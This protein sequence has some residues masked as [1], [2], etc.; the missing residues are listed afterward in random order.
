MMVC[1]SEKIGRDTTKN[2]AYA[3]VRFASAFSPN[4]KPIVTTGIVCDWAKKLHVVVT[5][6]GG[7]NFPNSS[8]FDLRVKIQ[9]NNEN[10]ENIR[11]DLYLHWV[12]MGFRQDNVNEF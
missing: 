10:N 11:D 9:T 7:T 4:C 5:G 1:G 3:H 2:G 8:G 12:A 6:P